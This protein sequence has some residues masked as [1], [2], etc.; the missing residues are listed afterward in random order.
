MTS[1]MNY[2]NTRIEDVT[3]NNAQNGGDKKHGDDAKS[4]DYKGPSNTLR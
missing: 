1:A 2:R 3:G 4:F